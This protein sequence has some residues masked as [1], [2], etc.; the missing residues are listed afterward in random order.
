MRFIP[1]VINN[2]EYCK[3]CDCLLHDEIHEELTNDGF[4]SYHSDEGRPC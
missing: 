1:A 2:K 4:C 3:V